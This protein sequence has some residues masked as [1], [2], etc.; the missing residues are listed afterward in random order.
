[1][2]EANYHICDTINYSSCYLAFVLNDM[3]RDGAQSVRISI[4]KLWFE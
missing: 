1:M 3:S 4:I 2:Y